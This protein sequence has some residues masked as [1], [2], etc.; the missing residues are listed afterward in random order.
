MVLSSTVQL[1][2][3]ATAASLALA[4]FLIA[5]SRSSNPVK[6]A[7]SRRPLETF[8][9]PDTADTM[10]L[11]KVLAESIDRTVGSKKRA[12]EV[13]NAVAQ[14]F[15]RELE[16]RISFTT[17]EV[18]RK[19]EKIIEQKTQ[20]EE[21]A[22]KRYEKTLSQ[23]KDTDAVIRSIAEGL[24]VVDAKGKVVMMN[25]AAERLLGVS[26][27]EKL[28]HDIKDGV[29]DDQLVSMV[30]N[31]PGS[32]NREIELNSS[33]DETKKILRASSAVIENENGQAVGMV[34]VLSDI[35]KQKELDRLKATFVANVSHELRT[36]L[37]AIDKSISL[38]LSKST[39]PLTGE[40]TQFLTIAERNLKRLSRL[41]NDLLD[42]SKLEA[43][44]MVITK[45][46][47][48]LSTV[49]NDA[50]DGV[51]NWADAKGI[52]L[53]TDIAPDL[54]AVNM[55]ADKIVQVLTNLIGNSIKFTPEGK[56]VTVSA[57]R[58]GAE[59]LRVSVKDEGIGI[60]QEH[61][62]KVF[63]KFFQVG[64]RLATDIHG[65]GIGLAISKEIVELHG[66]SIWVESEHG[67]GAT[68]TF[69]LPLK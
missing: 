32:E 16:K 15:D 35:T 11:R 8:G 58:G 53:H 54:P 45:S 48:S 47:A 30:K 19:Y 31:Q 17:Q 63:D 65:T 5:V 2:I 27:K 56:S 6:T 20:N 37:I 36:P 38:I 50:V 41:I 59:E 51:K 14:V 18:S 12:D 62:S 26:K 69:T 4:W 68:F 44:K 10:E 64:E 7:S 61:L 13:V 60:P 3:A 39:G 25:P 24:V 33:A 9:S 21:I 40:Q 55:D 22:W 42:L 23:K 1:Y 29:R 34:S 52:A 57:A 43:G 66:G 49:I 67:N 28:G 46:L